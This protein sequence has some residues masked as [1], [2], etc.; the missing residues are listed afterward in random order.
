MHSMAMNLGAVA[1]VL[2]EFKINREGEPYVRVVAR[3]GGL[4]SWLLT[5]AGIDTTTSLEIY[6]D[7]VMFAQGSLSGR[8]TTCMPLS[9]LSIA[10]CGFTKPFLLLVFAAIAF[11]GGLIMMAT[12]IAPIIG[13]IVAVVCV[14]Y[15]FLQKTLMIQLVS[16]SSWAASI[17]F[18]R[19]II[20]GVKVDYEQAMEVIDIVNQLVLA[21]T[22]K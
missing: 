6:A 1:L 22:K 13:L 17:C 7:R 9:A 8:V 20:E 19:S 3:K 2:K 10:T 21:Q 5:M 18:K 11:V 4:V 14:I 15:Y 16:N 12:V